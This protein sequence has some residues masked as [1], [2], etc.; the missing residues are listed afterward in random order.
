MEK[1]VAILSTV[2][3]RFENILRVSNWDDNFC[4]VYKKAEESVLNNVNISYWD[5]KN[6]IC[7]YLKYHGYDAVYLEVEK[8]RI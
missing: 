4:T 2:Q 5:M 3:D 8:L 7:K 6:E 1:Y